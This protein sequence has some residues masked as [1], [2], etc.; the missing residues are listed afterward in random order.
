MAK[1]N[2]TQND[3]DYLDLRIVIKTLGR[4]GAIRYTRGLLVD[5]GR[6]DSYLRAKLIVEDIMAN[7]PWTWTY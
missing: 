6:G 4:V 7:K 1:K 2:T 3:I 5:T